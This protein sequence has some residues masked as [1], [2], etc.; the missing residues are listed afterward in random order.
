MQ[1]NLSGGV[2]T[3]KKKIQFSVSV[4]P[5]ISAKNG[6]NHAKKFQKSHDKLWDESHSWIQGRI[7]FERK[8]YPRHPSNAILHKETVPV[9]P[10]ALCTS[11]HLP[12][13]SPLA[14]AGKQTNSEHFRKWSHSHELRGWDWLAETN[15]I[16]QP[17]HHR[18]VARNIPLGLVLGGVVG[19]GW[20]PSWKKGGEN[21]PKKHHKLQQTSPTIITP[22]DTN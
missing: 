21:E 22:K 9:L 1:T 12:L 7:F 5:D 15:R 16:H 13:R 14:L 4:H 2:S 3:V 18:S 17:I 8:N 6:L 20:Y 10:V 11:C 19:W